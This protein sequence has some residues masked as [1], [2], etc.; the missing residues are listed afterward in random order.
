MLAEIRDADDRD[1]AVELAKR[2]D[3]EFR[4]K[5]PTATDKIRDDLDRL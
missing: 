2:F 4:S 3:A 1:H 5:W